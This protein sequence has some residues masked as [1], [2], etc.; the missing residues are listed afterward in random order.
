MIRQKRWLILGVLVLMPLLSGCG[1]K[2]NNG[3]TP[4]PT[5]TPNPGETKKIQ[6][7]ISL[8]KEIP[9]MI[10]RYLEVQVVELVNGVIPDEAKVVGTATKNNL[11][12]T[13]GLPSEE[14][15]PVSAQVETGK[16][17][18]LRAGVFDAPN[19]NLMLFTA[20]C[21]QTDQCKYFPEGKA[22]TFQLTLLPATDL[23]TIYDN[24]VPSSIREQCGLQPDEA[25][26]GR[27]RTMQYYSAEKDTC[28]PAAWGGCGTI[29]PF[30]DS[31]E[32]IQACRRHWP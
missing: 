31:S 10:D 2:E 24:A 11:G 3:P 8:D 23:Q 13:Q 5:V 22:A 27:V 25:E 26:C 16:E 7:R 17:Y 14:A 6:V 30:R 19:R 1:R 28:Y 29:Q 21:Q 32:C 12:H 15:L 9:S 4:T 20:K 18:G